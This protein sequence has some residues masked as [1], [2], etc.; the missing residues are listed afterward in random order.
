LVTSEVRKVPTFSLKDYI[1]FA[2]EYW[3]VVL[4]LFKQFGQSPGTMAISGPAHQIEI[5]VSKL[6]VNC[7]R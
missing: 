5:Y 3:Q 1:S 4:V 6:I 7:P 2:I